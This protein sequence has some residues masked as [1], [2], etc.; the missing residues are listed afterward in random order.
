MRSRRENVSPWS[1]HF[2]IVVSLTS[3]Y[4]AARSMVSHGVS[5]SSVMGGVRGSRTS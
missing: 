5:R 3:A 1:I 4:R 2:S